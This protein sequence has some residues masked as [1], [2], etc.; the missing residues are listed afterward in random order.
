L[1]PLIYFFGAQLPTA[2]YPASVPIDQ[3]NPGDIW[4]NYIRYVGAGGVIAGGA[5]LLGEALPTAWRS[6]R[7][8]VGRWL[9]T[10]RRTSATAPAGETDLS[11]SVVVGGSV[12]LLIALYVLLMWKINPHNPG[13]LVSVLLVA[14][15][16]FFFVIVSARITG[17]MGSSANPI[18]GITIAVLML[19]CLLF[20]AVGWT[21]PTY[22]IV[23][24][25]IGA[26]VCIAASNAGTTAQDLKTG[27]LIDASPRLQ[28][29]GLLIGVVTSVLVIGYTL[30]WLNGTGH[31]IGS[32]QLP[33]PQAQ[34][35]AVLVD[36][37]LNHRMRW[38]LLM[39]G[40]TI[41]IVVELIGVRALP[42][43][44]G[45]YLPI[46]A[47]GALLIGALVAHWA[48]P[49]AATALGDPFR[50]GVLYSSGLIAGG[51]ISAIVV[52][53]LTGT[54]LLDWADL[55]VQVGW[56]WL[57]TPAWALVLFAG[58][59][60]TLWRNSRGPDVVGSRGM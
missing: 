4:S 20:V 45:M 27:Y 55:G 40:V 14:V 36:G 32:S 22:E 57:Q 26:I 42:F 11:M 23:A 6:V 24:V 12:A 3:M 31:R 51:A 28:Q 18:S 16:G 49:K 30:L 7:A 44:V 17:I 58:L 2:I 1:I 56:G 19:T 29:I 5:R 39:A 25:S 33:A 34:V 46:S 48:N 54:G 13:N 37:L 43:A 35:M 52:A 9:E 47:T 38:P 8:G 41:A 53:V 59:C 50:P 15:F 10:V 21:G 60:L